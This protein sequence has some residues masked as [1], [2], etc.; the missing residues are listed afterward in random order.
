M[1]EVAL[2]STDQSNGGDKE[3]NIHSCFSH[4]SV[5]KNDM[6]GGDSLNMCFAFFSRVKGKA[7]EEK[8]LQLHQHYSNRWHLQHNHS[9]LI[10]LLQHQSP[11][12]NF[13]NHARH[14]A[15]HSHAE[16]FGALSFLTVGWLRQHQG[17]CQAYH[18]RNLTAWWLPWPQPQAAQAAQGG[19]AQ[20]F[21]GAPAAA[22]YGGLSPRAAEITSWGSLED[23]SE[24]RQRC[25][26]FVGKCGLDMFRPVANPSQIRSPTFSN[27]SEDI[28]RRYFSCRAEV[29]CQ[30]SMLGA[31]EVQT[32]KGWSRSRPLTTPG[33]GNICFSAS[34]NM[35]CLLIQFTPVPSSTT[36]H[37]LCNTRNLPCCSSLFSHNWFTRYWKVYKRTEILPINSSSPVRCSQS[38]VHLGSQVD[39]LS[40]LVLVTAALIPN[41]GGR[42]QNWSFTK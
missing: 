37:A 20:G 2:G 21:H 3:K 10:H 18:A 34:V 35:K 8:I 29:H 38:A 42:P 22:S 36:S 19:T 40:H 5:L 15:F 39:S 7:T 13:L 1:P 41:L 33:L 25:R 23:L 6:S 16:H 26:V 30:R 32:L 9:C 28:S 27:N 31:V 24:K 11:R 17:A 4:F 14:V 12:F